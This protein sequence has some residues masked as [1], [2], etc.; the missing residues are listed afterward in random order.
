MQKTY[1]LMC[2]ISLFKSIS[3][4]AVIKSQSNL[5]YPN[6]DTEVA[7]S[8]SGPDSLSYGLD[9]NPFQLRAFVARIFLIDSCPKN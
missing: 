9:G 1:S 7:L 4:N 6:E 5:L 3:F 8:G 2:Q